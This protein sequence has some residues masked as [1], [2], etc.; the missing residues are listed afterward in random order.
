M[1]YMIVIL[2][3]LVAVAACVAAWLVV[4]EVRRWLLQSVLQNFLWISL[5][6]SSALSHYF[7][8]SDV[9]EY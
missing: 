5:T 3:L 7:P 6:A 9:L 1:D 4:P 8:I 2:S